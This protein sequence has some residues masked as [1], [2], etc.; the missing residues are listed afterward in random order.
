MTDRLSWE[1]YAL[2]LAT[3]ASLRSQDPYRKVGACALN[4][5][6]MV[7]GLGYNG[8]ASGKEIN[9]KTENLSSGEIKNILLNRRN[10]H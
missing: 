6:N 4:S 10:S 3:V 2:S 1:E 9:G 5:Q 7:I 8:L